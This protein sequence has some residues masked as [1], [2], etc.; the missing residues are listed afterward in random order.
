MQQGTF[1]LKRLGQMVIIFWVI[2]TMLFFLFRMGLPDPTQALVTEG[3]SREDREVIRERFGLDQPLGTQY[4]IYL[5]NTLRGDLGM[6]FH[7]KTSVSNI[8]YEKM[9]NTI[10][11]MMTAIFIA[12]LVGPLLGVLL[13]WKRGTGLEIG[14]IVSGLLMRSAPTFWTGMLAIMAFG[15]MWGIFPS[16]G[17]RTM[18]YTATSFMDKIL[19]LD[20]LHHLILP[21]L[22]IAIY[23]LG[24][25]MLIMRNTM[26]EVMGEDFIELCRAKGMPE[27]RVMYMHAARN[28]LLPVVTQAAITIGL[29][30]GGMVVVETVF[31]WPGVGRE[32]LNAVRT[33][34][35]PL[36]Q[37]SFMLM[38]GVVLIMNFF[39][40]LVYSYLDPRV[41]YRRGE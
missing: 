25:P 27:S 11:L 28:A 35:Y 6:S 5:R 16:S 41:V 39:S 32:M 21:A 36:A 4:F 40:D 1:I 23:Y 22:V 9:L 8:L 20:F 14:G 38:A 13:T 34:D 10:V 30:M 17:M 7:Y 12:Y 19:T 31:S 24:L 26:L 2:L 3:L 29:S 33:S 37:A 15:I 18:P